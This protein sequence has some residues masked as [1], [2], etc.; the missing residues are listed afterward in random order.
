MSHVDDGTLHAYLDGELSPPEVQSLETHLAQCPGCRSRL[1]EERA[2]I[3]RA[4]ELLW[5][6]APPDQHASLGTAVV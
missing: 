6:A 4:A 1:E 2:L 5:R 3:S